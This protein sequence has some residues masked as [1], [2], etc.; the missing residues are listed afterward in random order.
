MIEIIENWWNTLQPGT[1]LTIILSM[2][3]GWISGLFKIIYYKLFVK[4]FKLKIDSD[5]DLLI[6][7]K[8]N[9]NKTITKFIA[10]DGSKEI[11]LVFTICTEKEHFHRL[12]YN[13]ESKKMIKF[14]IGFVFLHNHLLKTHKIGSIV[15]ISYI[16]TDENNK[17]VSV[18]HS[19]KM[20]EKMRLFYTSSLSNFLIISRFITDI[21][22]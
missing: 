15:N 5:N 20:H 8:S 7:N 18:K 19:V 16:I 2:I 12:P 13:L 4:K 9:E 11:D 17:E 1:G 6:T 14:S 21:S 10:K 22:N 3:V